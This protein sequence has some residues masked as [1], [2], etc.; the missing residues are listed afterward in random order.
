MVA[1][2]KL[3]TQRSGHAAGPW[4]RDGRMDSTQTLDG[5]Q[6][7]CPYGSISTSIRGSGSSDFSSRYSL[8]SSVGSSPAALSLL[9][10]AIQINLPK[11]PR[12]IFALNDA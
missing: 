2:Q 3:L 12:V 9:G 8:C 11:H 5:K 7:L 1:A 4:T 6:I 10:S